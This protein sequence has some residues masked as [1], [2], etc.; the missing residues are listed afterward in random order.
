LINYLSPI[1]CGTLLYPFISP[2][3]HLNLASSSLTPSICVFVIFGI[4]K[5]EFNYTYY[6]YSFSL[7]K[8]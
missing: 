5:S 4:S 1:S 8:L 2:P 3:L 7:T 6:S